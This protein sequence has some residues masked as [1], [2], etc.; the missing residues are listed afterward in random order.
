ME[1]LLLFYRASI[2]KEKIIICL[3]WFWIVVLRSILVFLGAILLIMSIL[4]IQS[5]LSFSLA[6]FTNSFCFKIPNSEI[7][8]VISFSF[9]LSK[10]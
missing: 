4:D 9:V 2:K 3:I 7:I 6:F 5:F 10:G 8:P 1:N